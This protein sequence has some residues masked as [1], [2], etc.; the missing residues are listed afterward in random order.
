MEWDDLLY[1]FIFWHY[2][3]ICYKF[4]LSGYLFFTY[5]SSQANDGS[6]M[7][8]PGSGAVATIGEKQVSVGTLDWI[9]RYKWV[10]HSTAMCLCPMLNSPTSDTFNCLLFL[11]YLLGVL[12]VLKFSPYTCCLVQLY[13]V[14]TGV[15]SLVKF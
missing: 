1:I 13:V 5:V 6:F 8:E 9:K 2:L 15:C 4:Y 10:S 11:L 12:S 14:P 3:F 7:E